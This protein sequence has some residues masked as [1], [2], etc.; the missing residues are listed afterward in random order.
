MINDYD[1]C[2]LVSNIIDNSIN[3]TRNAKD[4]SQISINI[5]IDEKT[6][7]INSENE[8][9][10]K[11]NDHKNGDHGNGIGIIKEIASK[12]NGTYSYKHND[13]IWKTQ[14]V[15]NNMPLSEKVH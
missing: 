6:L 3:A 15:L 2:R 14:T 1:L 13:E 8:F 7:K 10:N 11:T 5:E 9:S 4:K 12:Y